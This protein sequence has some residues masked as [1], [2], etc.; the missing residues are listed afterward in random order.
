MIRRGTVQ[1]SRWCV[2]TVC[3]KPRL[4]PPPFVLRL[5]RKLGFLIVGDDFA[6]E[7][8]PEENHAQVVGPRGEVAVIRS[9]SGVDYE[10]GQLSEENPEA[11]QDMLVTPH[12]TT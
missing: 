2:P 10:Q 6:G 11:L 4:Y 12:G 9:R 8:E 3:P 7:P 5:H 1:P